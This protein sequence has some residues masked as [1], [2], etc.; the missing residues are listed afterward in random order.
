[1]KHTPTQIAQRHLLNS[2]AHI[3]GITIVEGDRDRIQPHPDVLVF[4]EVI[5]T[6]RGAILDRDKVTSIHLN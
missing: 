5:I 2:L 6:A 3:E 1:M 4:H